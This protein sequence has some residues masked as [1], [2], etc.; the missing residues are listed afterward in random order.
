MNEQTY[1]KLLFVWVS[2]QI[3]TFQTSVILKHRINCTFYIPL[4]L[5]I[6]IEMEI[7][8]SIH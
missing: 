5:E 3:Y 4:Q 1:L 8:I 7:T 6:I 2:I